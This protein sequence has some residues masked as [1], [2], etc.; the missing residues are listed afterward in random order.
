MNSQ[1]QKALDAFKALVDSGASFDRA[2]AHRNVLR[3]LGC[4]YGLECAMDDIISD[5][6]YIKSLLA[7]A[8]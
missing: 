5:M 6:P 1:E 7:G 2:M 3:Y 4:S 8:K